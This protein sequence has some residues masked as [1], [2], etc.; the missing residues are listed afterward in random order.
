MASERTKGK[1]NE[2]KKEDISSLILAGSGS[3]GEKHILDRES[4]TSL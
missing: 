1:I 3:G 4:P 2:K